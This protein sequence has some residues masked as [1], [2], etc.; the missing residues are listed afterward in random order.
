MRRWLIVAMSGV[1]A[2]LFFSCSRQDE[3]TKGFGPMLVADWDGQ[4]SART[5]ALAVLG[6]ELV[7]VWAQDGGQGPDL[8]LGRVDRWGGVREGPIRLTDSRDT[9]H[10]A[11]AAAGDSLVLAWVERPAG[12][13]EVFAAAW[14]PGSG[15]PL[16]G[17]NLSSSPNFPSTGPRL[18]SRGDQAVLAWVE[19]SVFFVARTLLLDA[20]ADPVGEVQ[21]VTDASHALLQVDIANNGRMLVVAG[22]NFVSTRWD[23]S[24]WTRADQGREPALSTLPATGDTRWAPA[25]ARLGDGFVAAWRNN[26]G[27]VP[28]IELAREEAAGTGTWV[29]LGAI[30]LGGF[31]HEPTV[32][33]GEK[34]A[35][36]LWCEDDGQ[37]IHLM[38]VP[39]DTDGCFGP[40]VRLFENVGD[41]APVTAVRYGVRVCAAW[42]SLDR[43]KGTVYLGCARLPECVKEGGS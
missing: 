19:R 33:G 35:T 12:M 38:A 14:R 31:P 29:V 13:M 26:G 28:A 39:V 34:T 24:F 20:S 2:F 9:R 7:V 37:G 30:E 27:Q 18:S 4:G 11:A 3:A 17:E 41:G 23:V 25:V 21:D 5:P 6:D 22:N 15:V 16:A 36:V 1:V 40:A 32:V 42:E 8:F 10:P 43:G